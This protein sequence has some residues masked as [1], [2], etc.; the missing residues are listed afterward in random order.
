MNKAIKIILSQA[1]N[2][3][4]MCN[5]SPHKCYDQVFG[6]LYCKTKPYEVLE[7]RYD[8]PVAPC[9]KAAIIIVLESPHI[10]E[11]DPVTKCGIGPCRGKTGLNIA[12]Y[13]PSILM[14]NSVGLSLGYK[15]YDLVIV[16]AIQY[17]C[18]LGEETKLYRDAMFLYYWEQSEVRE[19]FKKRLNFARSK[20]A[21][22]IVINCCTN[23]EHINL[24]TDHSGRLG[25]D[26]QNDKMYFDEL[27]IDIPFTS[28]LKFYEYSLKGCVSAEICNILHHDEILFL[29]EHPSSWGYEVVKPHLRKA[30]RQC[31]RK[32]KPK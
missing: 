25:Y 27:G 26:L 21:E 29:L 15:E 16:N 11:F 13:L 10:A 12:K 19:D 5:Y 31:C 22:S 4:G 23:G 7:K 6:T 17:Q 24:L 2:S 1:I 32:I 30:H 20:Y 8:I 28:D 14:N 18:S 9:E 3:Y